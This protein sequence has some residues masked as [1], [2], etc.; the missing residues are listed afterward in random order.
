MKTVTRGMTTTYTNH[1][2]VRLIN[3]QGV[4][5]PGYDWIVMIHRKKKH[6]LQENITEE[7]NVA[8]ERV[9]DEY[10]D[11]EAW[12]GYELTTDIVEFNPVSE[13]AAL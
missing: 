2:H 12:H 8:E 11:E 7:I 1:W 9:K 13:V 3:N 6:Q 4:Y 5:L 10:Y